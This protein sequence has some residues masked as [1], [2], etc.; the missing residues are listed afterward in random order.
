MKKDRKSLGSRTKKK[1]APKHQF[2]PTQTNP[3]WLNQWTS[4]KPWDKH[5]ELLNSMTETSDA[6]IAFKRNLFAHLNAARYAAIDE[7]IHICM[8]KGRSLYDCVEAMEQLQHDIKRQSC[9]TLGNG[10]FI[11]QKT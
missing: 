6:V 9:G 10:V 4:Q 11:G 8:R 1:V 3:N 5:A 7:C 2:M